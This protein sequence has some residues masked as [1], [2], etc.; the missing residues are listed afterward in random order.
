MSRFGPIFL[1]LCTVIATGSCREP[2][3]PYPY[4]DDDDDMY[5]AAGNVHGG[6]GD[7]G[8]TG[9]P[10]VTGSLGGDWTGNCQIDLSGYLYNFGVELGVE[11]SDEDQVVGRGALL[12]YGYAYTGDLSGTAEDDSARVAW[13][14]TSSGYSISVELQGDISGD[15]FSGTCNVVGYNGDFSVTR[16]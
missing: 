7:G 3:E 1:A 2:A 10:S 11:E 13:L 6:A 16:H 9:T 5:G 15:T 4:D 12:L 14:A 8:G